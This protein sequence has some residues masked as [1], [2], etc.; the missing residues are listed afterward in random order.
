MKKG[1]EACDDYIL[2]YYN[3]GYLF[4]DCKR[5]LIFCSTQGNLEIEKFDTEYKVFYKWR[6][7]GICIM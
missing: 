6:T 1:K 3:T 7:E 4:F 2:R 5:L